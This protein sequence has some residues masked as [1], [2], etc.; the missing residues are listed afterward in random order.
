MLRALQH[1]VKRG[2]LKAAATSDPDAARQ[3]IA[4]LRAIFDQ[5][6][7]TQTR[8]D[9]GPRTGLIVRKARGTATAIAIAIARGGYR[10]PEMGDRHTPMQG[11]ERPG[12]PEL[13]SMCF[14]S[15]RPGRT[16]APRAAR[17]GEPAQRAGTP[18]LVIALALPGVPR[19]PGSHLASPLKP[20][21]GVL[22]LGVSGRRRVSG[23]CP[24]RRLT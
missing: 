22:N 20:G 1:T 18:H 9:T 16:W 5:I 4:N 13:G 7:T 12:L 3:V 8:A 2:T 24:D 19:D 14:A 6:E 17:Q 21:R 10:M 15:L 11:L 23:L